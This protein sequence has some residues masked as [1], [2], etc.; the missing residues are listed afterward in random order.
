MFLSYSKNVRNLL[1]SY[2]IVWYNFNKISNIW[3]E[4]KL[5]NKAN[6]KSWFTIAVIRLYISLSAIVLFLLCPAETAFAGSI[7]AW[8]DNYYSQCNVP[9]PNTG[10]I[11]ISAGEL[12]SLGLKQDGT[13]VG[14]G[15]NVDGQA[16]PPD[17]NDFVAIAAGGHHSLG[18]KANGYIVGWGLQLG[19]SGQSA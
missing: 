4:A 17:G 2:A 11:A 9:L 8:G 1:D 16:S 18:L 10:F 14:W 6:L 15:Y 7:V 3:K 13:I 19:W 12:Y 5:M